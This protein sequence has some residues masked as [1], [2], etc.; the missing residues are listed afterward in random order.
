MVL[1]KWQII[2]FFILPFDTIGTLDLTLTGFCKVFVQDFGVA[3][4]THFYPALVLFEKSNGIDWYN[5]LLYKITD[6][7]IAVLVPDSCRADGKKR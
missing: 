5:V 7:I 6:Q 3:Y 2:L 1:G 4:L